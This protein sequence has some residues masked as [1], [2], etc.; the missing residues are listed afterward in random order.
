M[1]SWF[2]QS[3][4]SVTYC[5]H[6]VGRIALEVLFVEAHGG[7]DG[8]CSPVDQDICQK[9]LQAEFPVE[10]TVQHQQLLNFYAENNKKAKLNSL[11]NLSCQPSIRFL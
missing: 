7:D 8:A 9:F 5:I 1:V 10:E 3:E 4:G 6:S 11:L 2:K